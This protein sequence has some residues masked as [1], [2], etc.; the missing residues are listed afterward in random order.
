MAIPTTPMRRS[1]TA[2]EIKAIRAI[3]ACPRSGCKHALGAHANNSYGDWF[4]TV[5]ECN[6][7]V[8]IV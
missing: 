1:L 4:C 5:P 7:E 2:D 3:G 6:C 8:P